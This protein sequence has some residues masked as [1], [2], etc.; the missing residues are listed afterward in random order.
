[1]TTPQPQRT[2]EAERGAR[3]IRKAVQLMAAGQARGWSHALSLAAQQ[4]P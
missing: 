4:I 3:I 1:M 2:P